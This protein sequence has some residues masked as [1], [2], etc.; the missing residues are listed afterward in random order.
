MSTTPADALIVVDMQND[1][2]PGG[3][4]AVAE[5]DRI[6]GLVNQI[7]RQFLSVVL[8]QDWHPADHISFASQHEGCQPFDVID[9]PYGEQVLWPNHCVQGT[10]G[11]QFADGIDSNLAQLIVRKGYHRSIDS[12][13]AFLEADRKTQTG[14]AGYLKDR[15]IRNVYLCGLATDF[16]VLWSALDARAFGFDVWVIEDATKCIDLNGSLAA[17]WEEM[18]KAGVRR[19]KSTDILRP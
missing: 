10:Q 6:I 5:G 7:A 9:L 15:L 17:A 12:Y 2:L 14:L 8:T 1:F 19:I 13:S 18:T 11:A 3:S 4:L 16:C